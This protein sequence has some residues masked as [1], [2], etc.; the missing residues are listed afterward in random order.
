M[1]MLLLLVLA[2]LL[3]L[4]VVLLMLL[5][6]L[7]AN[8]DVIT[9]KSFSSARYAQVK[10]L[11]RW[12]PPA[13]TLVPG[14]ATDAAVAL[15]SFMKGLSARLGLGEGGPGL[16]VRSVTLVGVQCVISLLVRA[17]VTRRIAAVAKRTYE[18][19]GRLVWW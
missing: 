11:W 7:Q 15:E 13:T 14:E 4:L 10:K 2:L 18:V 1:I 12:K 16:R 19:Q 17:E 8:P 9:E 5:L 6:F 3:A